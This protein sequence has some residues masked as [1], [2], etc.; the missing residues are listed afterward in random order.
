MASE[1]S[2]PY[3]QVDVPKTSYFQYLFEHGRKSGY[4]PSTPAH[5]D[6]I[7]GETC[8]REQLE[9]D[10]LLLASAFRN[11]HRK[12]LVGLNRGSVV[13]V[14]S[15]NSILYPKIQFTLVSF[16]LRLVPI[17]KIILLCRPLQV[18]YQLLSTL[19]T[20][21]MNWPTHSRLAMHRIFLSIR[22]CLSSHFSPW[23][24]IH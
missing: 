4:D 7:T 20:W 2:S 10:C 19:R 11:V 21:R 23:S 6:G 12:G 5:I 1:F 22:P 14:F 3:P 15:P 18:S 9:Q 17:L 13:L 24:P 16:L 8:T